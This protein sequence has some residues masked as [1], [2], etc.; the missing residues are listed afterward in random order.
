MT[1]AA[2]VRVTLRV[3]QAFYATR[4]GQN[5]P[6][7]ETQLAVYLDGLAS[8]SPEALEAAARM[9]MRQSP[10]FPRLSDLLGVLAPPV[11][12]HALA[13]A[14]WGRLEAEIRRIGAYRG[15]AFADAAFGETV[16]QVFGSWAEACRYDTDSPGWAI[17]R[18]TFLA[19]FPVIVARRPADPVIL[20]GLHRDQPPAHIGPLD[21]LPAAPTLA[22]PDHTAAVLAEVE[23]RRLALVESGRR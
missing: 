8:Y 21:G 3:L 11:D 2:A 17:R 1:P 7:N 16:R 18:Q 14:A 12:V 20:P 9:W 19:L 22:A 13:H 10:F 5:Y 4:D 23:R 15:A 6:L